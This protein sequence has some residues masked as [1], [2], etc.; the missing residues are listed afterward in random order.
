MKTVKFQP[1]VNYTQILEVALLSSTKTALKD[2]KGSKPQCTQVRKGENSHNDYSVFIPVNLTLDPS[3]CAGSIN[4]PHK[5]KYSPFT[6]IFKH[7]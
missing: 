1:L 4:H 5:N 2:F 3:S 7:G 6:L